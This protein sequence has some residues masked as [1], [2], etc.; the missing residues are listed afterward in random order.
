MRAVRSE[1]C[2]RTVG[3]LYYSEYIFLSVS[4]SV[5]ERVCAVDVHSDDSGPLRQGLVGRRPRHSGREDIQG[6]RRIR[7]VLLNKDSVAARGRDW[8]AMLLK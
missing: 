1:C 3:A 8:L 2:V 6:G 7:G 5:S 4:L